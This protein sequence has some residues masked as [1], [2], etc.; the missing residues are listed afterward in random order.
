M[1]DKKISLLFMLTGILFCV[2]LISA[3]LLEVKV[4][5][6][7]SFTVTA[8]LLVFPLSYI[9]NDCICEVWGY[10]KARLMV[11]C[12]FIVNF[13]VMLLFRIAVSLPSPDYW[14]HGQEFDFVFGFAP[15]IVAASLAAFLTGSLM[16]AFVMSRMKA[17]SY[18]RGFSYRAIISTLSGESLDSLVFFPIAFAGVMP[19]GEMFKMMMVQAIIKTLYE[20][21]V[22]PVTVRTAKWMK[23]VDG[24]DVTDRGISYNPFRVK[25][26]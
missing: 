4:V 18:G 3:N 23:R 16:N 20:I 24:S 5:K 25:D 21:I 10:R 2:C 26:F 8:G 7:G 19:S 11:W 14:Q 1:G 17:A 9:L 15:R 6:I 13:I 12:G 22:L